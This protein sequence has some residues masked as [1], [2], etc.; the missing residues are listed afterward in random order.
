MNYSNWRSRLQ[1]SAYV[2][3]AILAVTIL[4]FLLETFSGGSTNN[5][6]LVFYGARLNPLILYGQWWRLMTPV[7][8]HIGLM[9]IL[10]NGFSLYY[11]DK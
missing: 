3:N 10:V 9:H 5:S 6:V 4:V 7:F 11:W 1:N 8:V 2:T